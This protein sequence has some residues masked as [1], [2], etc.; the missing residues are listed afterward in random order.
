[1]VNT[2]YTFPDFDDLPSV[3]GQPQG[4]LWGFFDRDDKKDE[5]GSKQIP[6]SVAMLGCSW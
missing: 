6:V 3:P 5:L 2:S 4:C 1:M